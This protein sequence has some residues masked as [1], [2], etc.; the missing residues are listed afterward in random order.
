MNTNIVYLVK[1]QK[2]DVNMD[3]LRRAENEGPKKVAVMEEDLLEVQTK[4][5]ESKQKEDD[6]KKRRRELEAE[7]EETEEKIKQNNGRQLQVKTNDELRALLREIEFLKQSKSTAEDEILQIMETLEDLEE[8]NKNLE[9]A[10]EE[11]TT[12]TREKKTEVAEWIEA[13]K[14]DLA[15]EEIERKSLVR[16]IPKAML[17][18]YERVYVRA[19]GRAIVPIIDGICQECHLQIPAQHYNELRRNDKLMTC[20]NCNRLIFWQDHEDFANI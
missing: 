6:L 8:E 15:V 16:D 11:L 17:N 10:V 12:A 5:Q 19:M 14:K 18:S 20:V 3:K 1:L 9:T 7:V 4:A 2:L 13:S